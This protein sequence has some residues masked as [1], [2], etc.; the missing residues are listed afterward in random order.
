MS[1]LYYAA[2]GSNLHPERLQRR[3]ASARL[4]GTGFLPGFTLHFRKRGADGSAKC[5]ILPDGPGA[6]FAIFSIDAAEK[7]LL[8]RIEGVGQGYDLVT[9]NVP[10]FGPCF[11]Y[12]ASASHLADGLP[13]FCWY[14]EM[15][16][17]GCRLHGFPADY[18]AAIDAIVPLRD[19]NPGRWQKNWAL[20]EK[21]L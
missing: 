4:A 11:S 15:V 14:R 2:Y 20:V 19:P 13:P 7:Y 1:D 9:L 6:H 8:D 17:R 21:M 3:L 10:G 5:T 18:V 12:M 16:L